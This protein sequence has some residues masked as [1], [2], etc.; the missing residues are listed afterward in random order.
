MRKRLNYQERK[1]LFE[2]QLSGLSSLELKDKFNINDN[3]TLQ[4]HLKLAEQE[5]QTNRV[6][7]EILKNALSDHLEEIR[8][9]ID[10]WKTS[11]STPSIVSIK[12]DTSPI[13]TQDAEAN[14]L[15]N[16]LKGHLPFPTL[17]KN[18]ALWKNKVTIY[19]TSCQ[20]V[21]KKIREEESHI[22][23]ESL[24][25]WGTEVITKAERLSPELSNMLQKYKNEVE[26]DSELSV[27]SEELKE[28][29][30]KLHKYLQEI[31]LRRDYIL[32]SCNLCPGQPRLSR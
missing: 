17:W 24:K 29:E 11:I 30:T 10:N 23:T 32:Y 8:K 13:P 4:R 6:K 16:S 28:I 25:Y 2:A 15:F 5:A 22:S 3:R 18:Y 21:M 19:I 20:R 27:L 26:A 12:L 1:K 31:Q 14:P 7:L 9:I